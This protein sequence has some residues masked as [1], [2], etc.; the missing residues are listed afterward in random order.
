MNETIDETIKKELPYILKDRKLL[1]QAAGNASPQYQDP[2]LKAV[3]Q[4]AQAD[5]IQRNV[6]G[7]E[8]VEDWETAKAYLR[9]FWKKPA[10]ISGVSGVEMTYE[11]D[12]IHIKSNDENQD[13]LDNA[14]VEGRPGTNVRFSG[15]ARHIAKGAEL[16]NYF[17]AQEVNAKTIAENTDIK[18]SLLVDGARA[19]RIGVNATIGND[20]SAALTQ[21][22]IIGRNA[23][24]GE[25]L[26][27]EKAVG[28]EAGN[29]AEIG[30]LRASNA[31]I[32]N[33]GEDIEVEEYFLARR[34][35]AKKIGEGAVVKGYMDVC[36]HEGSKVPPIIGS[37][38][39]VEGHLYA[40]KADTEPA[41]VKG[42]VVKDQYL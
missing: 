25:L 14:K 9:S 20:L 27:V 10:E 39:K 34:T 38:A 5:V 29:N 30:R 8:D 37:G 19:E 15:K 28:D 12:W 32:D 35:E 1:N 7:L 22:K 21:S 18:N 40:F 17:V 2:P 24:I 41:D 33:I 26:D 16:P 3:N 36:D 6:D 11:S 4:D 23:K 31:R 13:Y 42:E